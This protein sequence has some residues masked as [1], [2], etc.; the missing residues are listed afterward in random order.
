MNAARVPSRPYLAPW[1]R[2]ARGPGKIVLEHGQRLVCLEGAATERLLPALLPLLDGTRTADEIA[3]VLGEPA[4]PAIEQA[5]VQLAAHAVLVEGPPL[6]A[7]PRPFAEAAELFA[8]LRPAGRSPADTAAAV[9]GCSIA[10]AGGA[11]VGIEVARLLRRSGADVDHAEAPAPGCD[12]TVCAPTGEELPRLEE[13]NRSALRSG[14][15]WLQILPFDGL[16]AA[17]GPLYLPDDTC[18]YECF[19]LR[20][21][22]V[23]GAFEELTLLEQAP[24][25][26]PVPATLD[27]IVGGL[28]AQLV[29]GWL[30][31]GDH[32]APAAF[33]ALELMPAIALSVH[34]VHRVPRCTAC[35]GL[36]DTASPL[37]WYKEVPVELGR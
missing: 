15:P 18:C 9:A 35:S 5:L 23:H 28:A 1:Y 34:Y 2:L 6:D 7:E 4:R 27:S 32:Y 22:A 13:W 10:V 25:A 24:A 33:Y 26:Y 30:V 8:S 31:L 37:P 21:A 20:R 36:V 17:I 3:S 14:S 12:L 19:R 16:Y 11:A 29:L